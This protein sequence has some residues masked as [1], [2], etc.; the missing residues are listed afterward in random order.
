[1]ADWLADDL[2]GEHAHRRSS[3]V[4]ER[5][6]LEAAGRRVPGLPYT[7]WQLLQH[8]IWW[9]DLWLARLA[10]DRPDNPPDL[11]VTWDTREAPADEAMLHAAVVHFQ[12]GV[13]RAQGYT[14]RDLDAHVEADPP[15]TLGSELVQLAT[16]NSYHAGQVVL[17]RRLLGCWPP[18]R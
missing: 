9:Q 10:G 6:P 1:M 17:I 18:P 4:F 13:A 2:D 15:G 3:K 16:H 7:I 8:M 5:L 11:A 14:S 12:Q